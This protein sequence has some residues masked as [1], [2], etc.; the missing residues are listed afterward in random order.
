MFKD[1]TLFFSC[2]TPNLATVIPAMDIIDQSLS[3][4]SESSSRYSL[5]IHAALTI[6][7]RTLHKYYNK[8]RE[9][10]V[11]CIAMS[12]FV[13]FLSRSATDFDIFSPPPLSQTGVLQKERLGQVIN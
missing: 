1:A 12:T 10:N 13:P 7:K 11:Y 5:A 9:S 8:T 6:G 2:G 3:A 4:L